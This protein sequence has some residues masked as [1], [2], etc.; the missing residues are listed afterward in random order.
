MIFKGNFLY[1]YYVQNSDSAQNVQYFADDWGYHPVVEYSNAGPHSRA[2]T[3]FA[4]GEEAVK[5]LQNKGVT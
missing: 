2:R 4:L 1:R 3:Q 5:Q